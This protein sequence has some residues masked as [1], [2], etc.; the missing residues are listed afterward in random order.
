MKPTGLTLVELLVTLAIVA[1]LLRLGAPAFRDLTA[2]NRSAAALNQLVGAVTLAR[3]SAVTHYRVVT[4]CPGAQ[5]T[6][7]GR[8]EWHRGALVFVDGDADGKVGSGDAVL[9]RLPPIDA[10]GRIY[11]R[12]FRNR[13]FLQFRPNGYTPSQNG[14][15]LY[16]AADRD[17]R[18][19]RM[20]ILNAQGRL[21]P[22]R[23]ADGDGVVEDSGGK[24]V[25][26]PG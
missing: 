14:S 16:C 18:S 22:A 5:R 11:W 12:S 21:R 7:F 17:R 3:A 20:L 8:D 10:G 23:D 19:A 1:I 24:P 2:A 4:L 9:R 13:T 15:F 26:C 6:C 25:S